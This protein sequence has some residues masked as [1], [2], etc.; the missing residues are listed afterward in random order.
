MRHGWQVAA[1]P[2]GMTSN[3]AVLLA[4]IRPRVAEGDA[5]MIKRL[6]GSRPAGARGNLRPLRRAAYSLIL[7]VV[8]DGA[9]AEDWCK[10]PF[11]ACGTVR[12][13]SM[14]AGAFGPWL[15]SVARN[16]AIDYLAVGQR[17]RTQRRGMGRDGSP[18]AL[19]HMER[20]ILAS[21]HARRIRAALLKLAPQQREVIELA[22][23]GRAHANR[24]GRAN[25]AAA[26]HG[27][28]VGADGIEKPAR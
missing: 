23:F 13:A 27:E 21:D 24:N 6:K 18:V 4:A 5:E 26:G 19:I 1:A 10:R 16:R 9:I 25:G 28:D 20:D 8:R 14:R 17:T 7:R 22:Y 11:C 3:S 15:L 12:R 2:A